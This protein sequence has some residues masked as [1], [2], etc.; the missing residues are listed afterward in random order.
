MQKQKKRREQFTTSNSI[1]SNSTLIDFNDDILPR[2][3]SHYNLQDQ[4]LLTMDQGNQ[5]L[6][7]RASTMQSIESTI[8]ELGTIFNQLATMV[9]QQEEIIT[10][11]DSNV[12]DTVMNVEAAHESLLRYFAS[13]S[14]NRWLILKVFG[15]LF[16]FF[17]IFVLFA[18]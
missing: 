14:N 5:Y 4:Q 16:F 18:A 1:T 17:I 6:E 3:N 8:V 15:V 9:Q 11:I 2:N 12:T 13:V 10:R 7:E